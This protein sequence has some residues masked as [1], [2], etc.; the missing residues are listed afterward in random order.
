MTITY[1][2]MREPSPALSAASVL[3]AYNHPSHGYQPRRTS[4]P[5]SGIGTVSAP[6]MSTMSQDLIAE[7]GYRLF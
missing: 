1:A 6:R 3:S 5:E 2:G 4:S 7:V